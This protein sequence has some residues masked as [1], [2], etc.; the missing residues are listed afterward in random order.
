MMLNTKPLYGAKRSLI[1]FNKIDGYI[2]TYDKAR[3][4]ASFQSGNSDGTFH[5]MR[6]FIRL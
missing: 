3:E 2:R 1:I 6:Y 5:G 4:L